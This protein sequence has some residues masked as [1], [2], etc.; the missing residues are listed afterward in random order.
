MRQDVI[1]QTPEAFGKQPKHAAVVHDDAEEEIDLFQ[2]PFA[3]QVIT[4]S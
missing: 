4:L 3:Q 1:L 2:D